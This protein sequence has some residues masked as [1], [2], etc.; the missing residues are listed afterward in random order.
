[1]KREGG[2]KKGDE[3]E[4]D[5]EGQRHKVTEKDVQVGRKKEIRDSFRE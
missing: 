4:V 2:G 5:G 1:M 3:E